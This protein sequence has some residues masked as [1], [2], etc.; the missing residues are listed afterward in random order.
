ML[1]EL[2]MTNDASNIRRAIAGFSNIF[3]PNWKEEVDMLRDNPEAADRFFRIVA[4]WIKA[5][6]EN[7]DERNYD[8]RNEAAC[9]A[10]KALIDTDFVKKYSDP[11]AEFAKTAEAVAFGGSG[12][13]MK[14]QGLIREHRTIQ[15]SF[16]RLCF[17]MLNE[18]RDLDT[19]IKPML[20][21]AEYTG[22][23]S[24]PMI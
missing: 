22:N 9:H 7:L 12:M 5:L 17:K 20:D 11:N 23:S 1:N 14:N 6:A 24:F 16:T 2:I 3:S 15:Q 13:S 21:L 18:L 19:D 8:L 4:F 10:G